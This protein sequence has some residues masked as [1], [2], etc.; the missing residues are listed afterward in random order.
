M[1]PTVNSPD[2]DL[3]VLISAVYCAGVIDGKKAK[4]KIS[5]QTVPNLKPVKSTV[6]EIK[7]LMKAYALSVIG[8]DECFYCGAKNGEPCKDSPHE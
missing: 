7:Q 6:K 2:E 1:N 4:G 5:M 8:E 3:V